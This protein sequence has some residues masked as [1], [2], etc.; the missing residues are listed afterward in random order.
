V[1][2]I[3]QAPTEPERPPGPPPSS[4]WRA[5]LT[6]ILK[7]VA[8]VLFLVVTI[9][10][11]VVEA[12]VV[13]GKS[14][15]DT[16]HDGDR[17]LIEKFAPRF[18]S[19]SRGDVIIFHHPEEPGKRLIKRVIGLPGETVKIENG[20][21][22]IDGK[23]LAE[24]W[25]PEMPERHDGSFM[26]PKRIEPETYFVLGDNRDISNDSRRIGAIPRHLIVGKF[27]FRFYP[28]GSIDSK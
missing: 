10:T 7:T 22:F 11:F 19:I 8:L 1:D 6:E 14:M 4:R 26:E 5:P 13:H 21:V 17:L 18:E 24:P 25:L 27:L 20:V 16:F 28:L 15:E 9:R 3:R 12:Y 2:E 23:P